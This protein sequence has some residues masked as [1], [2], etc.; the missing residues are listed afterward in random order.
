MMMPGL[1]CMRIEDVHVQLL[2]SPFPHLPYPSFPCRGKPSNACRGLSTI[3]APVKMVPLPPLTIALVARA[4]FLSV[5]P[6]HPFLAAFLLS[7]Q[8]SPSA[9][10]SFI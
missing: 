5:G 4:P 9:S 3:Q 10:L 2:S 7:S 6:P 1:G 8:F